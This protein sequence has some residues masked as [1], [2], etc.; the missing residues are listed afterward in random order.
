MDTAIAINVSKTIA[1][2]AHSESVM[3]KNSINHHPSSGH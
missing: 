2:S 1:I 3:H